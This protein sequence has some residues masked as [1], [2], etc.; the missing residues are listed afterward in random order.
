MKRAIYILSILLVLASCSS[1]VSIDNDKDNSS[2]ET[3]AAEIAILPEEYQYEFNPHVIADEYKLIYGETIEKEF[4]DLCDALLN[5]EESFSCTSKERLY[6]L[7]AIADSCFPLAGELIDKDKSYVDNGVCHL[8]YRYDKTEM[9]IVIEQFIE[10]VSEI[11]SNAVPYDE[12]DYVK[13][14]ELYTAVAK[15]D[16]YDNSYTL[17]DALKLRSYRAIMDDTGICQEIACE[18]IYY[19]LQVGINAIPCSG[20]SN[21]KNEAHEWALIELDGKYYH[22]DPTYALNYPDSLFFFGL[23]DLQREY[24]GNL[25]AEDY[26]YADSDIIRDQCKAT[27]RR[28]MS[29]WM[30][31]DY[32]INHSLHKIVIINNN[33]GETEEYDLT[34]QFN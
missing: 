22:V 8:V 14:I 9:K 5:I 1:P 24:Y 26:V 34:D 25:P 13:A 10:K 12:P 16:R 33:T 6:Q 27:D 18:Y 30:A 15:K 20:L 3:A 21:D 7:L 32:E 19:L 11:I 31:K 28:F 4:Y 17:D 29:L 2:D 23:D